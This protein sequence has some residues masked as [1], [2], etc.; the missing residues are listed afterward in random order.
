MRILKLS[1]AIILLTILIVSGISV[2]KIFMPTPNLSLEKQ[3]EVPL[4]TPTD[5]VELSLPPEEEVQ[6]TYR[7]DLIATLQSTVNR[8]VSAWLKV[9]NTNIDYP[10][11][12]SADNEFYL[13]HNAHKNKDIN[14]AIFMDMDNTVEDDNIIFYGHT[15][16]AKNMF[17]TLRNFREENFFLGDNNIHVEYESSIREYEPVAVVTLDLTNEEDVFF[18]INH[19]TW[20]DE[21]DAVSYVN[22]F[23]KGILWKKARIYPDD[24]LITLCTCTYE[25][26]DARLLVVGREISRTQ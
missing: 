18:F 9:D 14:G 19:R 26:S 10:V 24:K 15:M 16:K 2:Y 13:T 12:Y 8:D 20:G 17:T 7:S 22:S 5:P 1:L 4:D 11:V 25:T 23:G 6:N 21:M 3:Y